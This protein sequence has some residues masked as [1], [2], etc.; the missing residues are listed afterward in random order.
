MMENIIQLSPEW[1]ASRCGKV[2][3]SRIADVMATIKTGEAAAR[4]NYRAELIAQRLTGIMEEGFTNAAMQHGTEHEPFA[5][6]TYEIESGNTVDTVGFVEHPSIAMSGASPDGLIG[7]DGLIEIKCPNTA[8]HIDYL[9][10]GNPP[11][12]YQS[13]MLWQ[14]ACTGRQWCEFVSFDPRL[15]D[16]LKM[17]V[18]R[19]VR[20]D[21]RIKEMESAVIQFNKEIDDAILLLRGKSIR[22]TETEE[23]SL[24][25]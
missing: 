20:D 17:F 22:L 23:L 9:I 7:D 24:V 5:R 10:K 4:A 19:F 18:V 25:A 14:M 12:K 21:S 3:A 6:A 13:Q 11:A 16:Y 15:P 1:F 8:T 2:T